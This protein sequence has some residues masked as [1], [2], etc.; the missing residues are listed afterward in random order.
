[1]LNI[2]DDMDSFDTGEYIFNG[3]NV[4]KMKAKE[5]AIFKN[6]NIGFVFQSFNLI[7][8]LNA[9]SNVEMPMP[10]GYAGIRWK[11]K[12]GQRIY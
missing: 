1:M 10:M 7:D 9:E 8:D 12:R 3:K 6:K 2:I 5:A 11:E 4:K